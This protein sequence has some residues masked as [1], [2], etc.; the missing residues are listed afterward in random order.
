MI[1]NLVLVLFCLLTLSGTAAAE[2]K[3]IAEN[4]TRYVA[5]EPP[6]VINVD[7][8]GSLR[9]LQVATQVSVKSPDAD[10]LLEHHRAPIRHALIML[11]S[12]K[13]VNELRTV[14]GKEDLRKQAR[15]TLR[16]ILKK[17]TGSTVVDAVYFTSFIIQ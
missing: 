16:N 1:K 14:A 8:N 4:T 9:F 12:G 2:S 17:Q 7:D 13:P 5:L 15:A 11:L 3:S 10:K 6:L